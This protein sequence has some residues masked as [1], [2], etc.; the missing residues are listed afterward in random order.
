MEGGRQRGLI[1]LEE[2]PGL[3]NLGKNALVVAMIGWKIDVELGADIETGVANCGEVRDGK[4]SERRMEKH[5]EHAADWQK[6]QDE[7]GCC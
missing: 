1:E 7:H 6:G 5:A 2:L 4:A 3:L